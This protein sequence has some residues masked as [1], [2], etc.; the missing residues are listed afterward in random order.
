MANVVD[1]DDKIREGD[2]LL[3]QWKVEISAGMN[4]CTEF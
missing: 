4:F 1:W 2:L 3:S